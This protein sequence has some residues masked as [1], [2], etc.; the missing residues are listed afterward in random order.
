MGT[1]GY[2]D[3]GWSYGQSYGQYPLYTPAMYK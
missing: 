1:A 3:E 2:G